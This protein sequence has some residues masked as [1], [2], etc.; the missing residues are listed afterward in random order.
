MS[1]A[2]AVATLKH[3]CRTGCP[4]AA[5]CPS[6][7]TACPACSTL[8]GGGLR[9]GWHCGAGSPGRRGLDFAACSKV[10]PGWGFDIGDRERHARRQRRLAAPR[11][12]RRSG[13][14][15]PL[16]EPRIGGLRRRARGAGSRSAPGRR[17]PAEDEAL[18]ARRLA[19]WS[20][21]WKRAACVPRSCAERLNRRKIDLIPEPE[22]AD[23]PKARIGELLAAVERRL[24]DV[25]A[26]RPHRGR[27]ARPRRARSRPGSSIRA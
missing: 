10:S 21:A 15:V 1:S 7:A 18:T 24:H 16:P 19:S 5:L 6:F 14:S 20:S 27:G 13:P 4:F 11:A 17:R 3:D 25:R 12:P 22:W 26:R 23:P 9:L 8:R 2:S